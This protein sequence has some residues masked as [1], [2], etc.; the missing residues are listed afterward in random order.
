MSLSPCC[1]VGIYLMNNTLPGLATTLARQRCDYCLD[2]ST[3]PAQYPVE[4]QHTNMDD[5]STNNT[6]M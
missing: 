1:A 4:Q 6:K 2:T 3:F 5:T